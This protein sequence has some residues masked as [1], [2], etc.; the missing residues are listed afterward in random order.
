MVDIAKVQSICCILDGMLEEFK[1]KI[2]ALKANEEN[3]K[4]CYEAMFVFAG[5]WGIGG[6]IGGG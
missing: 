5:I 4:L 2:E 6:A 1:G 3:L